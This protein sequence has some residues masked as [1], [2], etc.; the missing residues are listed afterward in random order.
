MNGF[1]CRLHISFLQQARRNEVDAIELLAKTSGSGHSTCEKDL[2]KQT[3]P[4]KRKYQETEIPSSS[5][6]Q[7]MKCQKV[8]MQMKEVS[9]NCFLSTGKLE[10]FTTTWKGACREHSVQQVC[11]LVVT[12]GQ[13]LVLYE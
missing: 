13:I 3:E 10:K 2:L 7:P 12:Y 9:P 5:C 11:L 1:I 8:Q 4:K 6:K